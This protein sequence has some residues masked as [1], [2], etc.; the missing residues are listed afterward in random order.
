MFAG[1]NAGR[2]CA[3]LGKQEAAEQTF[4]V[5]ASPRAFLQRRVCEKLLFRIPRVWRLLKYQVL[6]HRDIGALIL[7]RRR[8]AALLERALYCSF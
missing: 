3:A 2:C 8:A 5:S 6:S 1:R 7:T 4:R